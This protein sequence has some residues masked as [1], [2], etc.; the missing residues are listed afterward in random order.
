M[1]KLQQ[2]KIDFLR[3]VQNG[4]VRSDCADITFANNGTTNITLNGGYVLTPGTNLQLTA[5]NGE[6][7]TTIYYFSF[8]GAGTN[9]LTIF[10]KI[11]V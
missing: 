7:D 4:F 2:Y 8:S 9:S 11:Y 3:Y 1:S 10:R 6:I 5:N